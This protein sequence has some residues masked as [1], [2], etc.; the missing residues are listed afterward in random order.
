MKRRYWTFTF[1]LL[2]LA[3]AAPSPVFA[4]RGNGPVGMIYVASQGLY[5]E[6]MTLTDLP[7][8]GPF[9]ELDVVVDGDGNI[10]TAMTEY[11]PG[12]PGYLGGRWE[13]YIYDQKMNLLMV[14]YFECPLLGPGQP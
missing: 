6:T 2:L 10:L 13:A 4:G 12:D 7:Q 1:S 8:K 11:G 14:H 3:A 5:Y 9:Q